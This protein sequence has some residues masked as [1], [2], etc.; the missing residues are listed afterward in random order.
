MADRVYGGYSLHEQH[1]P[2]LCPSRI[3]RSPECGE[4]R[5]VDCCGVEEDRDI[6]ECALCGKQWSVRCSFDDDFS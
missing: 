3:G 6:V 4:A 5:V 1:K 2:E